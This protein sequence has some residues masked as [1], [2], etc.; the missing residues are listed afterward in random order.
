MGRASKLK[1]KQKQA[2]NILSIF[3]I[4]IAL[5]ISLIAYLNPGLFE[6]DST[7]EPPATDA[8]IIEETGELRVHVIDVGQGDS[9]H[10][11]NKQL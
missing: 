10:I 8:G 2:K 9:I 11:L 3:L 6:L 1:K 4:L 5:S 7:D